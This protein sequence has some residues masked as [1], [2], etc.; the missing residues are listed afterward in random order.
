MGQQLGLA[1]GRVGE[2]ALQDA[3]DPVMQLL[4]VGAQQASWRRECLNR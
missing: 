1:A 4:P 3:R 2:A